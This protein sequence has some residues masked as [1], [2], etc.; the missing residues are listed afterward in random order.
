[1][2]KITNLQDS[3]TISDVSDYSG[4]VYAVWGSLSPDHQTITTSKQQAELFVH[5]FVS[6]QLKYTHVSKRR[7]RVN[8]ELFLTQQTPQM[9]H[10]MMMFPGDPPQATFY[11]PESITA[12]Q[13]ASVASD[14]RPPTP[15]NSFHS[16]PL[17]GFPKNIQTPANRSTRSVPAQFSAP[18]L[19]F[20]S[21]PHEGKK[22]KVLA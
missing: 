18:M 21:V 10:Y 11:H 1:M 8:A 12:S 3:D 16:A 15:S 22:I 2:S 20:D 19:P 7:T 13:S 14:P 9:A 17:I 4:P 5:F 6:L